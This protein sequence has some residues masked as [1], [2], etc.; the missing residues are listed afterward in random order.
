[1]PQPPILEA[2]AHHQA[3]IK[4]SA[5]QSHLCHR[6]GGTSYLIWAHHPA[7]MYGCERSIVKK[8]EHRRTDDFKL[9]YWRK[10]LGVPWTAWRSNQSTLKEIKP[11]YSLE[12]LMLS[13]K[14][15]YFGHLKRRAD[16][17]EKTL[18]LGKIEGRRRRG[19]QRMRWTDGI[20]A[21]VNVRLSKLWEIVE[22][23]NPGVLQSMGL[24][25]VQHNLATDQQQQQD[26]IPL[27]V[28]GLYLQSG[29]SKT[30]LM[31]YC[32]DCWDMTKVSP[33]PNP[34]WAPLCPL[35]D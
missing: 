14:L 18:T 33:W 11:G 17:L 25:R 12:G 24:Q 35:P 22:E 27:S 31:E 21:S 7:V 23:G 16:S 19:R 15:Q 20:T 28:L 29:N 34:G 10:L 30:S 32:G 3:E 1:M 6:R 5:F 13:L 8:A 9:R 4:W 26:I 2:S